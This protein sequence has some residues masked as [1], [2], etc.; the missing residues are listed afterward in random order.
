MKYNSFNSRGWF[1]I[2]LSYHSPDTYLDTNIKGTLNV[3]QSPPKIGNKK[4][5][6]YSATEIG[7]DG[8]AESFYR[9]FQV[10]V[11]I[12]RSFN[13][14]GPRQSARASNPNNYYIAT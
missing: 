2:P 6:P 9:S 5:F 13:T 4:K 14:Y 3:L 7:A 1:A 11:V 10:P 8:L 12:I